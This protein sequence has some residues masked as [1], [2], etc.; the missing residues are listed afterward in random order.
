MKTRMALLLIIIS[1]VF[2]S[3]VY[4]GAWVQEKG[5][6]LN[7]LSFRRYISTAY[8]TSGGRLQSTSAYAK[9]EIDEYFEYGLTD[10]LTGGI[11]LSGLQSHTSAMGTQ[12]GVNDTEILGRYLLWKDDWKVLS[13][14]AFVDK[15]GRAAQF[16]VPP[17]NSKLNTG[18]A[19]LYGM[20]GKLG[21]K[22]D[23][24]WFFDAAL[25][26]VQRYSAGN[27]LHLD[28]EAGWKFHENKF[29]LLLQNYNTLSLDHPSYPQGVGYNL[30]TV[31]P[32]VVYW[33]NQVVG[34]QAGVAQDLYGQNVG[35][36]T[37]P[38]LASWLKF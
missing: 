17:Q 9:Y 37:G 3:S 10:R 5:H 22:T 7:I 16:N 27:Q 32:S 28:L 14:Q 19:I 12:R 4:A 33:I 20:S 21:E 38:F 36:G 11:Y 26:L 18:E 13:V 1:S 6:G 2:C 24:Y 30:I 23:R 25:G 34:F 31:A 8:W 35:K 29:W 15:L